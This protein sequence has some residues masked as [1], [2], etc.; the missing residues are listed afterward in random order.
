M[1][2][3]ST[4]ATQ[5]IFAEEARKQLFK[6]LKI[7]ADAVG[8]TLGPRGK[9]VIIQRADKSPLVSKDGVT[10]SKSIKLKD[11]VQR[12]GADLIKEAA[13]QTNDVAGDGTTTATVLTL[14]M[15]EEGLKLEIG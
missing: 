1:F 3:T 5:V 14:A 6:G 9:T 12:M 8:C 13:S 2:D 15:V 4:S 11:P 7:A 10:V